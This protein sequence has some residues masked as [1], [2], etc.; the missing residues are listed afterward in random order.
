M[1]G[2][3]LFSTWNLVSDSTVE[4]PAGTFM[5]V[6]SGGRRP[7]ILKSSTLK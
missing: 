5:T 1:E 7:R 6:V 4:R 3:S 2:L